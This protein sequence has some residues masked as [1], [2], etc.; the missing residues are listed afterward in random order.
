MQKLYIILFR[1]IDNP[2]NTTMRYEL[3]LTL[4]KGKTIIA[5]CDIKCCTSDWILINSTKKRK[6]TSQDRQ[7]PSDQEQQSLWGET[8]FWCYWYW[9]MPST[10]SP[11]YLLE[12]KPHY[13]LI[14]PGGMSLFLKF[15]AEDSYYTYWTKSTLSLRNQVFSFNI[16]MPSLEQLHIVTSS[17]CCREVWH[18][19]CIQNTH[20]VCNNCVC[21]G[22]VSDRSTVKGLHKHAKMNGYKYPLMVA[23]AHYF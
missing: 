5:E 20:F 19:L 11:L 4:N 23:T 13:E 22:M 3:K 7:L 16:N 10:F 18:Y 15:H 2:K 14:H 17:V 8:Y 6:Q 12:C 1:P 9:T 21:Y